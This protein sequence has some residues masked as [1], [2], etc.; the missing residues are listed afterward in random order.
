MPER[1]H[2][3]SRAAP[4]TST[5]TT[6]APSE[7]PAA[8]ADASDHEGWRRYWHACGCSWR[9]E[10]EISAARQR[11]LASQRKQ[12]VDS[13]RGV[14]P[15]KNIEPALTRADLEWLL[16]THEDG[17]GP[18]DWSDEQQRERTG[19]DLRGAILIGEDLSGLP[20]AGLLGGLTEDSWRNATAAQLDAARLHLE[21]ADLSE[22]QLQGAVLE[23]AHLEAA[24][25][26]RV[27]LEHAN[28][29]FARLEGAYLA[30]VQAQGASFVGAKLDAAILENARLEGVAL[31][32]ASLSG[33]HLEGA[34]LEGAH[35]G[36]AHLAGKR[37]ADDAAALARI[38]RWR[39]DI[40]DELSGACLN[41][42]FFD[43][44]TSLDDAIVGD[45]TYGGVSL[46]DVRWGGANLAVVDWSLLRVLG[47]ER[48]ALAE[49]WH[50]GKAKDGPAR[51]AELRTVVRA[52]R[53]MAVELR[54]QG[55][56]EDADRFAY[57]AQ[58]VQRLVLRGQAL[59]LPG[60]W[61]HHLGTRIQ[62][63][64]SYVFSLFLD[65]LAGYGYK[66]G[67]SLVLYLAVLSISA[68]IYYILGQNTVPHMS[69][70]NAIALSFNAFHGRGFLPSTIIPGDP[71]TIVA[72]IEG[73]AGL[74]IEISFIATFTQRFFAR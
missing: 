13:E 41:G 48:E 6:T 3:A 68:V 22:A 18:V 59:W 43:N 36:E 70:I 50:P 40:A 20:L 11:Q 73:L 5:A 9:R 55:L 38:R 54:N 10:P 14:Y 29:R 2:A 64:G 52:N 67:R 12:R 74:I 72:V 31:R 4:A 66:P 49:E 34:H 39:T 23:G 65:G 24:R 15:F 44:L 62:K 8:P 21:Q 63:F 27:R 51:L 1:H 17:L 19:L 58:V 60:P 45:E 53:Q 7:P 28:L 35:L 16:A 30:E 37:L 71:T 32:S 46:A 47:D 56:N 26:H 33:A 57:R 25:L 42:V 61:H 69:V